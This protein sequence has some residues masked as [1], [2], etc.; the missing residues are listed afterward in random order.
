MKVADS[1]S[2]SLLERAA[3]YAAGSMTA[4]ELD[5]WEAALVDGASP[6]ATHTAQFEASLLLLTAD[7]E[8][9]APQPNIRA[10]LLESIAAPKGFQFRFAGDGP[11]RPTPLPGITFRL[12]SRVV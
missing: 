2:E 5:E 12:L 11:F 4:C 7:F 10:A 8:P 3:L 9:V 1:E 6:E